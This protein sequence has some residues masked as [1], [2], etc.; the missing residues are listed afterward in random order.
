MPLTVQG[1][2]VD[3]AISGDYLAIL[4]ELLKHESG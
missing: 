1:L 2:S 3:H 4:L